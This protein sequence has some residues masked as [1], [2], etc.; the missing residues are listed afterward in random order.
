M[1]VFNEIKKQVFE[2]CRC[3]GL[4]RRLWYGLGCLMICQT[5]AWPAS[6]IKRI[7]LYRPRFFYTYTNYI[8]EPTRL[9]YNK[10]I[11]I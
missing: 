9:V 4:D 8:F 1:P 7:T 5:G 10:S 11:R 3:L 6:Q 2:P